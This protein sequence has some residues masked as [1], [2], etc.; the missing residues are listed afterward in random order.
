MKSSAPYQN[1]FRHILVDE[2]QDT[3]VLQYRWLQMSQGLQTRPRRRM[4]TVFA[5][6]NETS[7]S[8]SANVG[9]MSDFLATSGGAH[10]A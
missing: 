1:R 4:N 9:N 6:G 5:V 2:F 3:N 10:Q 7:R 8:P